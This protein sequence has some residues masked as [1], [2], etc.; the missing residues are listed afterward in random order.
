M[1]VTIIFR[2]SYGNFRWPWEF[3]FLLLNFSSRHFIKLPLFTFLHWL[4]SKLFR[5]QHFCQ[6]HVIIYNYDTNTN[7]CHNTFNRMLLYIST[8]CQYRGVRSTVQ[9]LSPL[10]SSTL[11]QQN[12]T[13]LYNKTKPDL[14]QHYWS[15]PETSFNDPELTRRLSDSSLQTVWRHQSIRRNFDVPFFSIQL[16]CRGF[17][18]YVLIEYWPTATLLIL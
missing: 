15:P 2:S 6:I 9:H 16:H 13:P 4:F 3:Y 14:Q 17:P 18:R 7:V 12:W 5:F 1:S 8:E 11:L 10:L